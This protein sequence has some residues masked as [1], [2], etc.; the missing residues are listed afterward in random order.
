MSMFIFNAIKP[1]GVKQPIHL[2]DLTAIFLPLVVEIPVHKASCASREK[3]S[4]LG[5]R[6]QEFQQV[7][8]VSGDKNNL[9]ISEQRK[10][11][12]TKLPHP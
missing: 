2:V 12:N 4:S 10:H 7:Q 1:L 5:V 11:D 6:C 3:L 9:H 8:H